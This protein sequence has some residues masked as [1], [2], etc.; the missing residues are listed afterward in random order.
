MPKLS[1]FKNQQNINLPAKHSHWV[2]E[3]VNTN[4]T[5]EIAINFIWFHKCPL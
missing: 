1:A 4:W 5:V 2:L 3:D